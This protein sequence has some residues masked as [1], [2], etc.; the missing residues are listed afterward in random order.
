MEFFFKRLEKYIEVR[1][2][3]A[4]TDIIVK[5]M[6]EVISVLG[7]VTKEIGQGRTRMP[8]LVDI[9]PTI[10]VSFREVSEDAIWNKSCGRRVSTAR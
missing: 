2:S 4:M 10:D 6:V 1:P 3:V 5:I 8:F 7:V 9:S